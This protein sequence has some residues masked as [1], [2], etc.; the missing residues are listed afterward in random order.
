MQYT[1]SGGVRRCTPTR[2]ECPLL[3]MLLL[4]VGL[5][6]GTES[7]VSEGNVLICFSVI[8][9]KKSE[10]KTKRNQNQSGRVT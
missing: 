9:N 1:T 5:T 10:Q 3:K 2:L 4:N 6:G 7:N 8:R